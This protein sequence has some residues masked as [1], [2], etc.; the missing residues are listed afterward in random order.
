MVTDLFKNKTIIN[1][2]IQENI[3]TE[4]DKEVL[5]Q[6]VNKIEVKSLK[7]KYSSSLFQVSIKKVIEIRTFFLKNEFYSLGFYSSNDTIDM[8]ESY[9]SQSHF[10]INLPKM[11]EK[12]LHKLML[13][14]ELLS[15]SID[16]ILSE[17][18]EYFFLEVNTEGQYDW[19]SKLGGYNLD[20]LLSEY[21][22]YRENELINKRNE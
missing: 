22:I 7:T 18:G 17:K 3:F 13:K 8:R 21:L 4:H 1:K 16:L 10:R 2:A 12:K 20:L 15:G 9:Q 5:M 11:I 19:V 6:R 14:L